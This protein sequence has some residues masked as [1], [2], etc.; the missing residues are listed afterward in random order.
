MLQPILGPPQDNSM[1]VPLPWRCMLER[2]LGLHT[3]EYLRPNNPDKKKVAYFLPQSNSKETVPRS[4][5]LEMQ[6]TTHFSLGSGFKFLGLLF[7]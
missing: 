6:L 4:A 7:F 3:S 1:F 2:W 5:G